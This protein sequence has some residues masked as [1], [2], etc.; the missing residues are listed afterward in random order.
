MK[1]GQPQVGGH[2]AAHRELTPPGPE[3]DRAYQQLFSRINHK[4][5]LLGLHMQ[6]AKSLEHKP[7]LNYQDYKKR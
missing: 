5:K 2:P 1:A 3:T 7:I 6:E 4:K